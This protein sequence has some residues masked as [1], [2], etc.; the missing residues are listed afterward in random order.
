MKAAGHASPVLPAWLASFDQT[1]AESEADDAA[2][3]HDC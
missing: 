2:L 1:G 3:H